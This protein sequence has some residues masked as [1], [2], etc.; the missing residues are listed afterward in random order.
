MQ[1]KYFIRKL[2]QF[3]IL[4]M[5]PVIILGTTVYMFVSVNVRNDVHMRSQ[6]TAELGME[7]IDLF[8][9]LSSDYDALFDN[10][11]LITLSMSKILNNQHL[12]YEDYGYQNAITQILSAIVNTRDYVDSVYLYL[13]NTRGNFFKTGNMVTNIDNSMD[14]EWLEL[15]KAAPR[16]VQYWF[17]KR[18]IKRYDFEQSRQ[19]VTFFNRLKNT[20]GV[21]V[22]NF[23]PVRMGGRLDLLKMYDNEAILVTDSSGIPIFQNKYADDLQIDKN[24]GIDSQLASKNVAAYDNQYRVTINKKLYL[25]TELRSEKF[26]VRLISLVPEQDVYGLL[27]ITVRFFIFAI[28]VAVGIS[29]LFSYVMTRK[30]FRQINVLLETL[31]NAENGKFI[32]PSVAARDEYD[33]ILNNML[34][35]FLKNSYLKLQLNEAELRRQTAELTALQLQINPHFLFNTLQTVDIEMQKPDGVKRSSA[36]IHDLSDILKYAFQN[37]IQT[38]PVMEEISSGKKYLHIQQFRYPNQF[39]AYWEYG[40]DVSDV[41][42]MRLLFQPL[43]ENSLYHGIKTKQEPGL[44]RVRIVKRNDGLSVR[45]TDNGIGIPPKKLRD[46]RDRLMEPEIGKTKEHIGLNNINRRLVLC[47][48]Q[49][50]MIKIWSKKGFGTVV[51]F[52]VPEISSS[53][54]TDSTPYGV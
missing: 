15:F 25:M 28:I 10:T 40:E 31:E 12:K 3:S 33:T 38:V 42:I 1:R 19:Y 50:S 13:Y 46:I 2:I 36:L 4:M 51:S 24:I 32:R 37:S 18:D 9:N 39:K 29:V 35:A 7:Y 30:S 48:G 43:L 49:Q 52:F 44:I 47:Y 23:D 14:K 41:T 21:I 26:G 34:N 8:F 45:V 54:Q 22:I 11:P 27:R 16:D 17:V 53:S 5:I 6:V 20:N